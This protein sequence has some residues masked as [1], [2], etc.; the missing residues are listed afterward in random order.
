MMSDTDRPL[1]KAMLGAV[2]LY[3]MN[4]C[5]RSKPVTEMLRD[6]RNVLIYNV[7][8]RLYDEGKPI[9]VV[10][11]RAMLMRQDKLDDAGGDDYLLS[12]AGLIPVI[13]HTEAALEKLEKQKM[14]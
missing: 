4:D 7:M 3:G 8:L 14:Q 6:D 5:M 12:L 13:E 10:T 1:E 11:V 9:D 2:L